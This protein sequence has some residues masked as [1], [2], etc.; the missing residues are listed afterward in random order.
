LLKYK[1]FDDSEFPVISVRAGEGK[2]SKA[3]VFTL[4]NDLTND[5]FSCIFAGTLLQREEQLRNAKSY[6]NQKLTVRFFGRSNDNIPRFP[7]GKAFR[8]KK[9]L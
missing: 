8:S 5:T 3:A 1:K 4:Q 6:I 2:L 9:D 7:V